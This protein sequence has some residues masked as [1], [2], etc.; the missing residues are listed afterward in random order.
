MALPKEIPPQWLNCSVK[1]AVAAP[2][3]ERDGTLKFPSFDAKILADY[4]EVV[5]LETEDSIRLYPKNM[6]AYVTK[7]KGVLSLPDGTSLKGSTLI[8][9]P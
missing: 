7:K 2:Q 4:P 9:P 3:A 1:I 8:M 6:V 5:E